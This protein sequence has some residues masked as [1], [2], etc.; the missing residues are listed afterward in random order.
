MDRKDI[1]KARMFEA[2]KLAEDVIS[3][4]KEVGVRSNYVETEKFNVN[5]FYGQ[6][7][8]NSPLTVEYYY[9]VPSKIYTPLGYIHIT[10]GFTSCTNKDIEK[11]DVLLEE[12]LNLKIYEEPVHNIYGVYGGIYTINGEE[13]IYTHNV[14]YE[15]SKVLFDIIKKEYLSNK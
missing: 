14:E 7:D 1:I 11:M 12:R 5:P 3:I 6:L 15:E 2:I 8:I 9:G 10:G 13:P 4:L